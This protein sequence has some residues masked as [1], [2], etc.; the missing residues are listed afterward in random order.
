MAKPTA[1]S[2]T[3]REITEVLIREQ[4]ITSGHWQVGVHFNVV[5]ATVAINEG[6]TLPTMAVQVQRLNL[7]AVPEPT[8]MSV[9]AGALA[10]SQNEIPI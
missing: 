1:Y 2:F 3:L 6:E 9:D 7:V 10:F 8:A 4:G 5:P